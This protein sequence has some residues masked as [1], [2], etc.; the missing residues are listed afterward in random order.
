MRYKINKPALLRRMAEYGQTIEQ[1]IAYLQ[2]NIAVL[3]SQEDFRIFNSLAHGYNIYYLLLNEAFELLRLNY[4]D[5][6][7]IVQKDTHFINI[8]IRKK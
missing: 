8:E 7:V 4:M 6:L 1:K 2:H 5:Y 3:I